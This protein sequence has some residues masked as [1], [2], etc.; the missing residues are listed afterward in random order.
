MTVALQLSVTFDLTGKKYA[1]HGAI[2]YHFNIITTR[3]TVE[4]TAP[5]HIIYS[6]IPKEAA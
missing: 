4:E 2:K 6:L 1:L 3:P 5:K